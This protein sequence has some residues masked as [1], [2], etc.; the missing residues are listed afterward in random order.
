MHLLWTDVDQN[1]SCYQLK[2]RIII[3]IIII[4]II[5]IIVVVKWLI[6]ASVSC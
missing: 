4:M 5:I 1:I 3:I 6:L 2:L